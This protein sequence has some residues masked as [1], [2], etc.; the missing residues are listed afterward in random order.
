MPREPH[1][2]QPR[3]RAQPHHRVPLSW[4]P[5]ADGIRGVLV[6]QATPAGL[7]VGGDFPRTNGVR[8]NEFALFRGTT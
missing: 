4:N 1:R 7:G 6:I 5:G 2:P 8:H 3:G